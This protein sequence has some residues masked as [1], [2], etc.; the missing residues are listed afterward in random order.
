LQ[1]VRGDRATFKLRQISHNAYNLHSKRIFT[2]SE[3]RLAFVP[4]YGQIA[5]S[6]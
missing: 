3:N 4:V 5:D 2:Q 6:D 1:I